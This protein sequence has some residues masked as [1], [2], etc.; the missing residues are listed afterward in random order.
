MP[1]FAN[2]A[3]MTTSTTGTGTITL[4]SAPGGF[5]TFSAAGLLTGDFIRYVIEDGLDW[6][7]GTGVYTTPGATLTRTFTSS[8][9]GSLLSLSGS[10]VVFITQAVE[11]IQEEFWVQ[12]NATYTLASSTSAQKLF[13][14][15]T[16]GAVSLPIGTYRYE[17]FL[18][19][20]SMSA[21]TGNGAFNILGAGTATI[22]SALSQAVGIDAAIAAGAAASQSYWTGNASNAAIVTAATGTALGVKI[23]GTF[24]VTSAGTIIPSISLTTSSA[25][26]VQPNSYFMAKRISSSD[27]STT[28]GQWS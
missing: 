4:D 19:L 21:T 13:N 15:S 25:A 8:S 2:R 10:A 27:T 5:Q 18:Q 9:T 28:Y 24:R 16:N 1:R 14:A 23:S 3:K 6:E 11:D 17:S 26:I 22:G 12:L 20:T 7:I